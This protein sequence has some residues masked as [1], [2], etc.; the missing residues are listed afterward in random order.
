L[1]VLET[2]ENQRNRL[3][4]FDVEG[5]LL[6]KRRYLPFEAARKL[7]PLGFIKTII[8]GL[9]YETGLLPLESALRKIYRSFRGLTIE[10][11]FK[12]YKA[13]PLISG[14]E[15]LFK[16]LS[17]AGYRTALISSG[18]PTLLVKDL[19]TRLNADHAFGFELKTKNGHLTGE[20]GGEAIKSDGKALILKRILNCEDLSSKDCV[21]V[22][23][24]RNNLP[25]F[26][27]CTLRIGYNPD[28]ILTI[29]SDHVVKEELPEV[30]PIIENKASHIPRS[31]LSKGE[32]LREIIHIGSF[33]I[34]YLCAY[35]FLEP[36]PV[37]LLILF[38]TM[39][40]I[41]SELGRLQGIE[42]PFFSTITRRAALSPELYEFASSPILFAI[43]IMLSLLLFPIP[44]SYASVAVLTLGDGFAR[45]FGRMIG[46]TVLPF[47]KGKMVEGSIFGFLFALVGAMVFVDPIKALAA[48]ATGMTIES[49]PLPV[50][51]NLSLP[52]IT[53]LVLV[54]ML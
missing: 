32:I 53:G 33:S 18:L 29:K 31:G 23:D 6:P 54:L 24:D 7:G 1:A 5:V 50:N 37:S 25:M 41:A 45:I 51:D 9:L 49:L 47:N 28:F 38:V 19:A 8:I 36:Y 52:M 10:D 17:Q 2:E 46:R 20:I 4:V 13:I 3:V 42:F 14:V 35:T 48:A 11:L 22:A 43:G 12:P 21:V 15:P 39:L 16:K 30:L 44:I 40:Y 26:P 34:P 27:L